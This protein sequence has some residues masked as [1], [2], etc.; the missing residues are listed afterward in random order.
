MSSPSTSGVFDRSRA[1]QL[2]LFSESISFDH[3]LYKQDIQGSL[4]HAQMLETI[5]VL[6]DQEYTLIEKNLLEIQ[7]EIERGEFPFQTEL[8][9]IHMHIEKALTDRIGD[10]GRKLHTG[11]S[12]NDQVA[13]DARLWVRESI[14]HLDR[15]LGNLQAA[16]LTRAENEQDI[17]LPAYTHLQRA[18]PVTAAH[19]WLAYCEK[20]DRDRQRLA[21]CR[22][23]VNICSLGSAA[24]AG[25]TLPLDRHFVA[26]KL[27]FSGISRNSLDVSSDRDFILEFVFA[28]SLTAEHLSTW[29]DEWVL[30]STVEFDFIRLPQSYCTGSSI[31]PQKVN[32]DSL[33]L[34]RGK[35]ARVIGAL[36]TLLVLVK[37]LP[38]AYNRDLQEDKEPLFDAFDTVKAC[39]E[40]A[41]PIV[42]E[43]SLNVSKINNNIDLGYLDA[44]TLMEYLIQKEIPQRTAHHL[45]GQIVRDCITQGIA[46][47]ELT[48]EQFQ[49]MH[50]A[51]EKDIFSYLGAENVVKAY[52]TYGSSSPDEVSRQIQIWVE[53]LADFRQK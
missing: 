43:A 32:P 7:G 5:G 1:K 3:R 27:A 8:E 41:T 42:Q 22:K 46:L 33:E 2:E 12:R 10:A 39:L 50:P 48:I 26:E 30:W 51:I 52:Q 13:T 11:R 24:L 29:A 17:I 45:V 21:D 9:D 53:K 34:I 23:R 15:L 20:F 4:A 44:T 14:D 28:L 18:Q 36:S 49:K 19:Y 38:L 40:I 35:T 16:F 25:T 6:T 31:M 47:K 37:G